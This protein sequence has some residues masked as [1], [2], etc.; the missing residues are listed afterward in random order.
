MQEN[1]T[2]FVNIL[3]N[4]YDNHNSLINNLNDTSMHAKIDDFRRQA[5][6]WIFIIKCCIC[7]LGILGNGLALIVINHRSL[8]NTTSRVFITYLAIFDSLTLIL[9]L[10]DSIILFK[11]SLILNCISLYLSDF[12][13]LTSV[14]IMVIMTIERYIAVHSPFL[15]KRFCTIEHARYSMYIL[16][17][18][19]FALS[20]KFPLVYTINQNE[21][22]CDVREQFRAFFRFIEPAI[23]YVIPGL[24]LLVNFFTIYELFIAKRQRTQMLMNPDNTINSISTNTFSKQQKVLTIMLLT[25]S[26][27]FYLFTIPASIHYMLWTRKLHNLDVE[28]IKIRILISYVTDTMR[29]MSSATNFL[30]YYIAGSKFREACSETWTDI[31]DY[32][33]IKFNC[34]GQRLQSASIP[35]T[36]QQYARCRIFMTHELRSANLAHSPP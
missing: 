18:I 17:F 19:T 7:S 25:D 22:D 23:F 8:R 28:E 9:M 13:T 33:R 31:Y 30:F 36:N 11:R 15:A 4:T 12:F 29:H 32:I 20:L 26:L 35:L 24:I 10:T 27:S 2:R 34:N 1:H 14:W 21:Q 6:Y 5:S 16:I 3:N